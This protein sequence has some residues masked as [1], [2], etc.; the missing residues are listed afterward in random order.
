MFKN[1]MSYFDCRDIPWEGHLMKVNGY[2]YI[3]A[4]PVHSVGR[5][6]LQMKLRKW[7]GTILAIVESVTFPVCKCV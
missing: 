1:I 6:C 3:V 2:G 5:L 7:H 4:Y